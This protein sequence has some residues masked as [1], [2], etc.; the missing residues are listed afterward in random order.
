LF[1]VLGQEGDC[2]AMHS[3]VLAAFS[4]CLHVK[5]RT[6]SP[7]S[8]LG[9]SHARACTPSRVKH[10]PMLCTWDGWEE[11]HYGDALQNPFPCWQTF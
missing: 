4:R 1:A 10:Q 2:D 11:V 7:P 5:K 9:N 3:A 6:Y 8:D